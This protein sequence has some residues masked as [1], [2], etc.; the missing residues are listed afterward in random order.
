[1]KSDIFKIALFLLSFLFFSCSVDI[2]QEYKDLGDEQL[3]IYPD[4]KNVTVPCNVAPLNFMVKETI[5]ECVV[6]LKTP[7]G[8]V[9]G[10]KADGDGKIF[11]SEDEWR[12]ILN[13]TVGDSMVLEIYQKDKQWK[14]YA[15]FFI[16]VASDSIDKYI[17]YRLIEPAYRPTGHVSLVQFDLETGEEETIINNERPLNSTYFSGQTCLNCHSTQKNGSGN[18]MFFYRG[19]GGGLI[20]NYQGETRIINTKVKGVSK[21]TVY[22]A[23][24]PTQPMI[25]FSSTIVK[26]YFLSVGKRKIH[27]YNEASDLVL[28]DVAKNEISYIVKDSTT[29][30]TY[31]YWSPDGETIYYASSDSI[32]DNKVPST[33][34]RLKYDIKRIHYNREK[35]IWENIEMVYCASK[36]SESATQPRISPDGNY[37]LF[38]LMDNSSHS[39]TQD[40]SDL[41]LMD[42][43]TKEL[44]PIDPLNSDQP[45]GYHDWSTNGRWILVSSRRENG[46]HARVFISHFSEDGKVSKPFHLPH[47]E[48][49]WDLHRLKNY[50]M[51]EF[52]PTAA[53]LDPVDFYTLVEEGNV[54]DA[55]YKGEVTE[56]EVDAQTGAS[57]LVAPTVE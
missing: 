14:R 47:N 30:D 50:N 32:S 37:L 10:F 35:S 40:S 56:D 52:S 33:N 27:P 23:W 44:L 57:V 6:T 7:R 42:L 9:R 25:A 18:T 12:D 36:Q 20:V 46:N 4:Y 21:G 19:K 8:E 15:P 26:Q 2:P 53:E 38:A 54:V 34:F 31:P 1:M 43:R 5:G 3:E 17:T 41:V 16:K 55:V 39:Y 28:Y 49:D 29:I 48:P 51:V 22:P 13:E 24:H 45:E 11:F